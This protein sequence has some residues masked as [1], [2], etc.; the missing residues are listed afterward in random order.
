MRAGGLRGFYSTGGDAMKGFI[1]SALY[2]RV[3]SQKQADE[4]TIESQL[5]AIRERVRRD[6]HD[7]SAEFEFSDCGYSGADL[8]RPAME[9]LRDAV[10]S[11]TIDQVYVH[12]PDRLARKLAH[13]AILLE[14][15]SKHDCA[16]IFLNQE[17]I[18]CTPE[19][20]LLLQMQGMI[21]EYEREKILERTRRGRRYAAKQGKVSIFN[22]A[23]FG[24]RRIRKQ[25]GGEEARWE[26]NAS[27]AATVKLIFE[28]VGI[29]G[30]SLAQVER[31]LFARG[32]RTPT[33]KERWDRATI[34]GM[35]VNSA[36]QGTA[37]YGKERVIPRKPGRRPK[38]GDPAIPRQ[39]KVT[40]RTLP[41]E[42]ETILVP[43][44][45][46]ATLFQAVGERME[47][48]RKRQRER[49]GEAKYLLSGL[50]ICGCCGSAYCGR[51]SGGGRYA[52]Y[53]CIGGDKFRH[54]VQP[55]CDNPSVDGAPLEERVWQEL[56]QLLQ[57]P[58]R[59]REELARRRTESKQ[60]SPKLQELEKSVNTLRGRLD[61]LID[62][63]TSGWIERT[64]FE[65][66]IA[67]LR[68]QHRRELD[69]LHGLRG[70]AQDAAEEAWVTDS[71]SRL[72][73]QVATGLGQ[74]DFGLK[75]DLLKLL[76]NRV[77]IHREEIRIVYRVPSRPFVHG[78]ASRGLLQHWLQCQPLAPG[79]GVL[80]AHPGFRSQRDPRSSNPRQFVIPRRRDRNG[81]RANSSPH[82]R[83][84]TVTERESPRV[85]REST[86]NDCGLGYPNTRLD[87]DR[88]TA[89]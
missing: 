13:Q 45:V 51:R 71:L 21:A 26:V 68:A 89:I 5:A 64:E 87:I 33:G 15:F 63:H 78:P 38:R 42:Q 62:A 59:V 3:S 4:M 65:S 10:A 88:S 83:G 72:S 34:R 36:Y 52:Y 48:N 53:R 86:P 17:G 61:R 18:P 81:R 16:V 60:E 1:R 57:N 66:R 75:R 46:D 84:R 19:A 24:Y 35:L 28:L 44:I 69:A 27:D 41:E 77:E 82:A 29:N 54:P 47:E 8:L 22:V 76:I 85:P 31:E 79:R 11:G 32:I 9:R 23:P 39:S 73:Q 6:G 49:Q 43:A 2:A 55:L 25:A 80:A 40:V 74:A 56:C 70:V 14:E 7:V 50:L 58:E 67:N 30:C 37:K 20:N 12:S